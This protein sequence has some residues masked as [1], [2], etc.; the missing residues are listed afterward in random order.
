VPSKARLPRHA[1]A[2][3]Y[4]PGVAGPGRASAQDPAGACD[5]TIRGNLV[6]I[7]AN[8]TAVPG[9]G[10]IGPLTGQPVMEGQAPLFKRFADIDA[11]DLEVATADPAQCVE[12]VALVEPSLGGISLEDVKAPAC[13]V[14][15]E[16][17]RARLGIPVFHDDQHGAGIISG[18]TLLNA[19]DLVGT[20][21]ADAH[22]V[23]ARAGAAA[24]ARARVDRVPGARKEHTVLCDRVG[25]VRSAL[26]PPTLA[27]TVRGTL[28]LRRRFQVFTTERLE[29]TPGSGWSTVRAT[30]PSPAVALTSGFQPAAL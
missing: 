13:L 23:F 12:S 8:G 1:L 19:L 6:A 28:L 17:L 3:A 16:Q 26:P 24:I 25:R 29:T 4:T 18:A 22:I 21:L 11:I 15:K 9:R 7:I 10:A 2:L 14:I 27:F 30:G 20:A 5:Y